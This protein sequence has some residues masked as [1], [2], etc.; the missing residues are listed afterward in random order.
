MM[1]NPQAF[2]AWL[3]GRI[4]QNVMWRK[5][6]PCP[7]FDPVNGAALPGHPLCGGKGWIWDVA[8]PDKVGVSQ[9]KAQREWAQFGQWEAGDVIVSIQQN[10]A[11]YDQL[12]RFDRVELSNSTDV[13]KF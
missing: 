7:C 10:A 6:N 11:M 1:L 2:N 8:I 4:G 3:G 12:G 13:F 9:Q 5:G